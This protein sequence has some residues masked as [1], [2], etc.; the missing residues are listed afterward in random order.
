[1]TAAPTDTFL[2]PVHE[3]DADQAEG[4]ALLRLVLI[5]SLSPGRIVELPL[6]GGAV[7][8]GRNGRGKTSL[9]QLLLLFY[10][11]SPNRIVTAEAGRD[12]F[13]GYYLPRSSPQEG[14]ACSKR[15]WIR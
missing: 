8:T 2:P 3:M 15:R 9:L 1:M 6:A 13:T 5:D 10:G 12:S 14:R 4:F 11:E 7:L